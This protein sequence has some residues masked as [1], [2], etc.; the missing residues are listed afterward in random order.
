[1]SFKTH[2]KTKVLTALAGCILLL[3]FNVVTGQTA[4]SLAPSVVATAEI[5]AADTVITDTL[6][7]SATAAADTETAADSSAATAG[8]AVATAVTTEAAAEADIPVDPQVYLNFFYYVLLILLVCV[9]VAVLGRI[10]RVYELTRN[11]N[12]KENIYLA[13][14]FQ[15]GLFIVFL[16]AGLYGVYWSYVNHGAQ[17]MTDAATE[18]GARIDVLFLITTIIVTIVLVLTHIALFV[19]AYKYRAKPNREAY[20]YPHNNTIEQVWTIVPAVVLTVLVLFGFF[21]WRDITNIPTDQQEKAIK[22]EVVGEQFMWTVRYAGRD[23]V[24]GERNYKLTTPLNGTG[25]DFSDKNSWDDQ[26]A[27]EIVLPVGVP[28]RFQV[29]SKDA[30]HSFYIPDFRVQVNAVPGMKTFFQFTPTVTTQ[31][32]RDKLDDY[33]YDYVMLCAKIC[34]SSHFNMQ[35]K[36]RVVTMEEYQAWLNEQPYFLTEDLRKE[37]QLSSAEVEKEQTTLLTASN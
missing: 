6:A 13:N 18:H 8:G 16:I 9:F 26:L 10:I 33:N 19:F 25:I 36:V 22:I 35:R 7:L 20:Y 21:T 1:M 17:A 24:I 3:P 4:D 37:F 23:G 12:G 27:S 28:V 29:T 30:L 15:A 5:V 11:M 32:M 34:G 31:D 2:I 14:N